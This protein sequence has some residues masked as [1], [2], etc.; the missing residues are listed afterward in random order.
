MEYVF[1]FV[2]ILNMVMSF[3]I[4]FK[5]RFEENIF[6]TIASCTLLLFITGAFGSLF[7]GFILIMLANIILL[8]FNIV[9]VIKKKVSLKGQVFTPGLILF[10]LSYIFFLIN[11]VGRKATEWDEFSHWAL[12]VKNMYNLGNLG[13]GNDSTV[14]IKNYLSGT[15]IFQYFCT[16]LSGE[17]N[18][19]MMYMGMNIIIIS[20]ILPVFRNFTRKKDIMIYFLF[21]SILL[22]PMLFYYNIYFSLY[23]DG[24]LGMVFAYTIYSYFF[25]CKNSLKRFTYTNLSLSFVMLVLIKDFGLLFLAGALILIIIDNV[26]I[27]NKFIFKIKEIWNNNKYILLC[28]IPAIC[29]KFIWNIVIKVNNVETLSNTSSIIPVIKNCIKGNLLPY[30]NTV[31]TS[32]VQALFLNPLVQETIIPL[33]FVLVILI[34]IV[35][36]YFVICNYRGNIKTIKLV[37]VLLILGSMLYAT[38][39]LFVPYL[40]MFGEYEA[41]RLASFTRYMNTYVIGLIFIQLC[42]L[43]DNV[44][45]NKKNREKVIIFFFVFI[46][47]NTPIS[48]IMNLS[49]NSRAKVMQTKTERSSYD[50]LNRIVN[51]NVKKNEKV[52]F[53]ATNTVGY[54][55]YLA[56]YELTPIQINKGNTWSIGQKYYEADIWTSYKT[57]E[58]WKDELLNEYDYVYLYKIDKEFIANFGKLFNDSELQE[59]SLYRVVDDS[60]KEKI[61]EFV[62]E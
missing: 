35:L 12:V 4:I 40:S 30:Q 18:E 32:Y 47:L 22:L 53:I 13:L 27:K 50:K 9:S 11:V 42:F 17:F 58:T 29:I 49:A 10:V 31:I 44:S 41:L 1:L 26:F 62:G 33:S 45:E 46:I 8:V 37:M 24:V 39:L 6:I 16:R 57:T 56:K 19:S 51:K 52:Y 14:M 60:T 23:V 54:E 3:T 61:L 55:Y 20:T 48:Y 15:S 43:I 59:N 25:N 28:V 2:L 21:G 34:S 7:I 5:N 36:A 38:V